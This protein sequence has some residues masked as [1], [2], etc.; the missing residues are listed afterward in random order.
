M[1]HASERSHCCRLSMGT[2]W[3]WYVTV[4]QP[5]WPHSGNRMCSLQF[6]QGWGHTDLPALRKEAPSLAEWEVTLS[7]APVSGGLCVVVLPA[8]GP[9]NGLGKACHALSATPGAHQSWGLELHGSC[10]RT[11]CFTGLATASHQHTFKRGSACFPGKELSCCCSLLAAPAA[12][13]GL[14]H[15][16]RGPGCRE[17][18]SAAVVQQCLGG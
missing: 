11:T 16:L 8:A 1:G 4:C 17:E 15:H 7:P 9:G 6:L 12:S 14:L 13:A 3:C 5:L 2:S 18:G 10:G